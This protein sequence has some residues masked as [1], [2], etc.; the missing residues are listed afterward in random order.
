MSQDASATPPAKGT[1]DGRQAR[2]I[3]GVANDRSI[4][5]GIAEACAAHGAETR[6]HLSGRGVRQARPAARRRASAR[7]FVVPCDVGDEASLDA[8]FADD[9]ASAGASS[10]SS[11]MPSRFADKDDLSGRYVDTPR[12]NFLRRMDISCYSF[13]AVAA[14]RRAADDEGRQRC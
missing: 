1:P 8:A 9:R 10:I 3:M 5:W 14:A 7:D 12:A 6:L 2:L 13:T 11:S 4:A